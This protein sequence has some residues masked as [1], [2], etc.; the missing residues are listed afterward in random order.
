MI[1][2]L[3]LVLLSFGMVL[4]CGSVLAEN[5]EGFENILLLE[6][7]TSHPDVFQTALDNL[8]LVYSNSYNGLNWPDSDNNFSSAIDAN[9]D[10]VYDGN[11]DLIVLNYDNS[12]SLSLLNALNDFVANGGNLIMSYLL[13][14]NFV[15]HPLWGNLGFSIAPGP[16]IVSPFNFEA[17]DNLHSLF[18]T[19]N[20]VAPLVNYSD[21]LYIYYGHILN[22]TA[23]STQVA[24]IQGN[25][26][27]GVIIVN[28]Q[29][30]SIYNSLNSMSFEQDD[31]NDGKLDIVELAEN[32][33]SFFMP[34]QLSPV[35]TDP[36]LITVVNLFPNP[37]TGKLLI[38]GEDKN[39]KLVE[40]YNLRGELILSTNDVA[41]DLSQQSKGVYFVK[42]TDNNSVS[43]QKI[44]LIR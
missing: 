38:G 13:P 37:T 31:D 6:T 36:G 15:G 33:I 14:V 17:T 35:S 23:H 41:I 11:W 28:E 8:E 27:E 42:V 40:I 3:L 34:N 44:T 9:G 7:Y 12:L 26:N 5:P 22:V 21:D 16:P 32:E 1:S 20:S 4:S 30:T 18:S 43:T 39:I 25:P 29:E 24:N 2:K 19:P 10:G